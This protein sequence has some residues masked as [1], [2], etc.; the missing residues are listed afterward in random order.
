MQSENIDR[1]VRSTLSLAL[2]IEVPSTGA[3]AR[4]DNPVWDSLKHVEVIFMLEDE[5]GVQFAEEEFALLS[6]A[7]DITKLVESRLAP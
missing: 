6:S 2:G 1:R 4:S 3:F 5:F 7:E